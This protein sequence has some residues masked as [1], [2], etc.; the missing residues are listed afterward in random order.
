METEAQHIAR[1]SMK[2]GK[3]LQEEGLAFDVQMIPNIQIKPVPKAPG[4]EEAKK[5]DTTA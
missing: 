5:D 4:V 3:I 1:V 2:I